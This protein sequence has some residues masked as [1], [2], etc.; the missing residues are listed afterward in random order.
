V[1]ENAAVEFGKREGM[2]D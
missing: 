2:F 1:T